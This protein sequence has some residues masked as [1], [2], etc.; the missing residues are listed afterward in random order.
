M[1]GKSIFYRF[2]LLYIWGLKWIHKSNFSKR[3][4]YI[5]SFVREGDLVLEPG[6]GPAILAD[7][8]PQGSSYQGFDTNRNF[9]NHAKKRHSRVSL[10]DVLDPNDYCKATA[11]VVCDVLH[12]IKPAD[13]KKLIQNCYRS[14]DEIFIICDPGKKINHKPNILYPIWKRLT[15]WGEKDGTNN[16]KYEY[17]LTRDQLFDEI[18]SGF[19]IIPS[20]VK[21]E[22]K[23]IGDDIIAVFIKVK[24]FGDK[25]MYKR[26]SVSA[27]VPV[28]NEE[29]TVS[30]VIDTLL[31]NNL[32]NEVICINDGSTDTSMD[33]L[34]QFKEK[35]EIVN[36]QK[37]HGKGF[38]LSVGIK[39]AKGDIVAFIDADLTNLSDDHIREL[40]TPI[41][42]NETR[43]VVGYPSL[44]KGNF[45]NPLSIFSGERAYYKK[46]LISHVEE[47]AETRFG[48]EVF[49]NHLFD[50]EEIRK[51][52]LKK[53]KGLFKHEKRRPSNTLTEYH[54]ELS[55]IIKEV[56]RQKG[57]LKAK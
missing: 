27:I 42:N 33:V 5:T 8:L 28:Y 47:M 43:G 11:V 31:K 44:V 54:G 55:E 35:I 32:I 4:Q 38:A 19:G 24:R 57:F 26:K 15:E 30:K 18:D 25:Q 17:F 50:Q 9:V 7:F 1:S 39:Q 23:E 29:K 49:L 41:L 16:F 37:N 53:L 20:S 40:L 12:H 13:R 48:V 10:G 36:L 21:R 45:L 34:N 22:V 2:P 3:Y 6:C 56:I 14:A 46:D 51:V 52:P